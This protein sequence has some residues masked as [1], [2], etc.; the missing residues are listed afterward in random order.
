MAKLGWRVR[1]LAWVLAHTPG[2]SAAGM[3]P[4][5]MLKAQERLAGHAKLTVG[6]TGGLAKGVRTD[7]RVIS[8]D[9]Q[10]VPIRI[11]RAVGFADAETQLQFT[12]PP[13]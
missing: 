1:S 8:Q 9:G 10:Q 3:G 12:L 4:D 7:N 6:V 13:A 2:G 11:Y 5:E